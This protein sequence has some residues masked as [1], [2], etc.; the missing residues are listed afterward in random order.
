MRYKSSSLWGP[1][2]WHLMHHI[3]YY[4]DNNNTIEQIEFF[5]RILHVIPCEKCKDH[6]NDFINNNP[7]DNIDKYS[8]KKWLYLAHDNVNK[9]QNIKGI[10]FTECDKLYNNEKFNDYYAQKFLDI[11]V[12]NLNNNLFDIENFKMIIRLLFR[13]Y[14]RDHL[15]MKLITLSQLY[16]LNDIY[17]YKS[18]Y[19]WYVNLSNDWIPRDTNLLFVCKIKE[20]DK[21]YFK[22]YK[23]NDYFVKKGKTIYNKYKNKK[24]IYQDLITNKGKIK[25]ICLFKGCNNK[26][27]IKEKNIMTDIDYKFIKKSSKYNS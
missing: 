6:Y 26:I 25:R 14:P 13:L 8:I 15:R 3:A 16:N 17:D 21:K 20:G 2:L 22:T 1:Y 27:K 7:I 11:I 18:L 23:L 5:N 10:T 9:I 19:R 24:N 4:N 12:H